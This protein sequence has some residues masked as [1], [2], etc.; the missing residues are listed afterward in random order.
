MTFLLQLKS[1]PANSVGRL[2]ALVGLRK[3]NGYKN[4]EASY[5]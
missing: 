2:F 4:E 5:H 3:E 1:L